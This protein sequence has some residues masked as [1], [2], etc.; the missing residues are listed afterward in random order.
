MTAW[1]FWSGKVVPLTRSLSEYCLPALT[2]E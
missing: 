1:V 2:F